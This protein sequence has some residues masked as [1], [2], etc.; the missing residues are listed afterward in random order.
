MNLAA[1]GVFH[2]S[3]P[4]THLLPLLSTSPSLPSHPHALYTSQHIPICSLC[5]YLPPLPL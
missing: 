3:T 4:H 2:A 1:E 5:L